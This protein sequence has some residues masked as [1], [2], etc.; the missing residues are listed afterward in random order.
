LIENVNAA[1]KMPSVSQ[2]T[3]QVFEEKELALNEIDISSNVELFLQE[4]ETIWLLDISSLYF[5]TA[6]AF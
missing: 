1:K 4:T 3:I 5:L 6:T 2:G